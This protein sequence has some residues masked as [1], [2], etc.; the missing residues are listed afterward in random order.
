MG[1]AEAAM[2]DRMID[3]IIRSRTKQYKN[4]ANTI[5]AVAAA[6]KLPYHDVIHSVSNKH[7]TKVGNPGLLDLEAYQMK[8]ELRRGGKI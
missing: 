6:E 1:I 8:C 5:K 3:T 2:D 4:S 7:I